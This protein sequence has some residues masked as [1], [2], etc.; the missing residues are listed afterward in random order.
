M[1]RL[2]KT[3]EI[4]AKLGVTVSRFYQLRPKLEAS[5]FPAPRAPFTNRW[6]EEDVDRWISAGK[7]SSPEGQGADR[8]VEDDP[9][10]ALPNDDD[11]SGW[12][13]KLRARAAQVNL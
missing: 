9:A 2:I 10:A 11:L 5:G 3:S 6:P 8:A 13:A 12:G 7:T 4:A 1:A